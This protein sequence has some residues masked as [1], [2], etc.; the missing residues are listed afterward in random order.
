ML[1][2][3]SV[4]IP[5]YNATRYIH[6]TVATVLNQT[7]VSLEVIVVDDGSSDRTSELVRGI[8]DPRV[9]VLTRANGG[10]SAARN[11]GIREA[12]ARRFVAFLDADDAWDT[13]KLA[14][15]IAFLDAH[16]E[17]AIVGCLMRYVSS[18]GRHIGR[19]GHAVTPRDHAAIERA[20]LF[21]FPLSSF[22]VRREALDAAGGFDPLLGLPSGGAE[23]MDLLAR[24]AA[25]GSVACIPDV[26]GSYRIHPGSAMARDRLRINRE[27]RFVRKRLTA[28]RAG[29]D[30]TWQEFAESGPDTAG[31]RRQ[32]CVE[33]WYRSAA[34]WYGEGRPLKALGYGALAAALNPSYTFRRLYRQRVSGRTPLGPDAA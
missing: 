20:E 11:D 13:G 2:D 8:A 19:S 9:R 22:L 23:D 34:L 12:R 26:L 31:E 18:T 6:D 32:D 15:Q 27:A 30:L 33:M 10:P 16:Q 5:A 29:R 24:L 28:R 1:P 7:H 17:C 4:V 25:R 3:V 21:P 14:Q